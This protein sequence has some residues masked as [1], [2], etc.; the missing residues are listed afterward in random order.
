[1]EPEEPVTA[2]AV[3]SWIAETTRSGDRFAAVYDASEAHRLEH[4]SE[5][6]VYPSSNGPLLGALVE[7]TSAKRILEIG[8]GLGYSALWLAHGSRPNGIVETCEH[9]ELHAGLAADFFRRNEAGSRVKV[10]LGRAS[11]ILPRLTGAFDFIFCDGDPD[12]YLTDLDHFLRLLR[13]GGT[14]VSSNLFLGVYTPDA[15]WLAQVAAYRS[16][17]L[18]DPNLDTV[19]L[20]R[21]L[22]VSVKIR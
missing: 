18:D 22:A 20:P 4:G 7:A 19:F 5:C 12:Q 11:D 14:L 15:P 21:G 8:C 17:L 9:S 6:D 10:H 3:A 1:M 16:R 2:A 13:R